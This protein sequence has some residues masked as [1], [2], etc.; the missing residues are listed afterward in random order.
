MTEFNQDYNLSKVREF[1]T[2]SRNKT[3]ILLFTTLAFFSQAAF[4]QPIPEPSNSWALK[5]EDVRIDKALKRWSKEAG[6]SFRWDAD[7]Y[8]LIAAPSVYEGTFLDAVRQVL[9]TPGIVYSEYPL[10]ACVYANNPP[11][12]R[13][14]RLGDQ[15]EECK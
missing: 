14:T 10:E 6:Y 9:E 5:L 3:F 8:V 12:L 4:A 1:V 2:F 13:V 11:L 15:A 7:R